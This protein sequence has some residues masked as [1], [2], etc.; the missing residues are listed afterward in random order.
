MTERTPDQEQM[1]AAAGSVAAKVQA[2]LEGL[3]PDERLVFATALQPTVPEADEA[4][5]DTAGYMTAAQMLAGRL[6][7]GAAYL[8]WKT[9]NANRGWLG[10]PPVPW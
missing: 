1:A 9:L 3:T 7:V 10:L 6:I 5:G 8:E 2:F 4:A